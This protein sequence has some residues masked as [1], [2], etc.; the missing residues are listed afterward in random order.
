MLSSVYRL[1]EI[2]AILEKLDQNRLDIMFTG[3]TGAGKSTTINSLLGKTVANVGHGVDPETMAVQHY[4][5]N[6]YLFFWD[7]PGLGDGIKD[8]NHEKEIKE[9]LRSAW[10]P[11]V[12]RRA[13]IDMVVVIIEGSKRDLGTTYRL[14]DKVILPNISSERVCVAINQ[15]DIAMKGRYWD[16]RRHVPLPKLEEYLNDFSETIKQR[17]AIPLPTIYYSASEG[18][19]IDVFLDG[20]IDNVPCKKRIL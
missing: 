17:I 11:R 20:I 14:L 18:Y 9:M 19:N 15:S 3:V 4:P 16:S 6:R 2:R 8:A 10:S 12:G 13:L 5:L 1:N 7:T